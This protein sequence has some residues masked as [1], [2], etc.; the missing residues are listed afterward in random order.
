[1]LLVMYNL[2]E[3]LKTKGELAE[4]EELFRKALDIQRRILGDEHRDTLL[5]MRY[6]AKLLYGRGRLDE[7]GTLLKEGLDLAEKNLPPEN[8]I[9]LSF[10]KALNEVEGKKAPKQ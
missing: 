5:M 2:A 8:P 9:V 6:L 3:L 7:A 1:M 10:R 4:A